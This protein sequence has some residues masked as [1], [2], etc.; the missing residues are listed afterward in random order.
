MQEAAAGAG[1][2]NGPAIPQKLQHKIT[3]RVRFLE[4]VAGSSRLVVKGGTAKK[5]AKTGISERLTNYSSLAASLAEA[6]ERV[7][8]SQGYATRPCNGMVGLHEEQHLQDVKSAA[9]KAS[10]K[11]GLGAGGAKK[12]MR[13]LQQETTRLQQASGWDVLLCV[14]SNCVTGFHSTTCEFPLDL[15]YA[16]DARACAALG[17]QWPSPVG[18]DLHLRFDLC[19]LNQ[20]LGLAQYRAD[21]I[22]AITSHLSSTLPAAPETPKP[23]ATPQDRKQQKARRK[24]E[25]KL[26]QQDASAMRDD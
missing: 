10:A 4:R 3:K 20:V 21:P 23:K 2:A 1:P 14:G 9:A 22:A 18:C 19:L 16:S 15:P 25:E 7:S 12:R 8:S 11:K 13:I 24:W 6:A 26:K 17:L 5:R